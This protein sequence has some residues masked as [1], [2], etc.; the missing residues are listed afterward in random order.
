[1]GDGA[2]NE[3]EASESWPGRRNELISRVKMKIHCKNDVVKLGLMLYCL[4]TNLASR[5]LYG[6]KL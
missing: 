6:V 4:S 5:K 3:A 1:M 2:D